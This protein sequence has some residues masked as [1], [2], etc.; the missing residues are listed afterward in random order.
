MLLCG[1]EAMFPCATLLR[2]NWN[3]EHKMDSHRASPAPAEAACGI[4][5]PW[6]IRTHALSGDGR[7]AALAGPPHRTRRI[8]AR[9][10]AAVPLARPAGAQFPKRR[11]GSSSEDQVQLEGGQAETQASNGQGSR[12]T[13]HLG[14]RKWRHVP[15]RQANRLFYHRRVFP[16]R[17][18]TRA[19]DGSNPVG[20]VRVFISLSLV[21][22]EHLFLQLDPSTLHTFIC[23]SK[24]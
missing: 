17:Y 2:C 1:S 14:V 8:H 20:S 5:A 13:D 15:G 4:L 11:V 7:H 12:R 24:F 10:G 19:T 6:V 9:C 18:V 16:G 3:R 23:H 22:I 21:L